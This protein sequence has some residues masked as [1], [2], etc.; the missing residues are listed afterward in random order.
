VSTPVTQGIPNAISSSDSASDHIDRLYHA[1]A[2]RK[3]WFDAL[4]LLSLRFGWSETSLSLTKRRVQVSEPSQL[5]VDATSPAFGTETPGDVQRIQDTTLSIGG[6]VYFAGHSSSGLSAILEA[7]SIIGTGSAGLAESEQALR[8]LRLNL[9]RVLQVCDETGGLFRRD[10]KTAFDLHAVIDESDKL[11]SVESRNF[12]SSSETTL[13]ITNTNSLCFRDSCLQSLFDRMRDS[14]RADIGAA[15]VQGMH[16]DRHARLDALLETTGLV[17]HHSR[18]GLRYF[19]AV[20]PRSRSGT[21]LSEAEARIVSL[22]ADGMTLRQISRKLAL[23]YETVRSHCKNA[24]SKY[25]VNGQAAMVARW[26]DE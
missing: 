26:L 9:R 18:P 21:R 23:S 10:L 7:V 22:L 2:G 4:D 13:Q 11:V 6:S 14:I 3:Y 17:D 5:C 24:M 25:G 12:A 8:E 20:S 19:I 1:I 15:F 16:V